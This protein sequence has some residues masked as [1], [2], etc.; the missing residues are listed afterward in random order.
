MKPV[1][2]YFNR[3]NLQF[4]FGLTYL[5]RVTNICEIL[6][7]KCPRGFTVNVAQFQ[8]EIESGGIVLTISIRE[9]HNFA[10]LLEFLD[11]VNLFH[12]EE[13]MDIAIR[14]IFLYDF[15]NHYEGRP[16]TEKPYV[17]KVSKNGQVVAW[18]PRDEPFKTVAD[19]Y[20]TLEERM[21]ELNQLWK[22]N[23]KSNTGGQY[24]VQGKS[25]ERYVDLIPTRAIANKACAEL[26][27]DLA[28]WTPFNTKWDV[29]YK[30]GC[31]HCRIECVSVE[32]ADQIVQIAEG[33]NKF[34]TYIPG[35]EPGLE[36]LVESHVIIQR[37]E[38]KVVVLEDCLTLGAIVLRN[39]QNSCSFCD[40]LAKR[41]AR[42]ACNRAYYCNAECQRKDWPR[43]KTTCK[44][45]RK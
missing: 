8:S 26:K 25:G 34:P 28:E 45:T 20:P 35:D 22:A 24:R 17:A 38:P 41:M 7:P 43:H 40:A 44:A 33:I 10:D 15:Q 2:I 13:Y 5:R 1:A 11:G 3:Y 32:E 12:R 31:A 37:P 42:C 36:L 21:K 14:R 27:E 9:E 39:H 30:R 4:E 19:Y 18:N 16:N 6:I 23:C 29:Q